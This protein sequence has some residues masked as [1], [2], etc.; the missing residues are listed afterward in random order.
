M[1]E[2]ELEPIF[3][4]GL[5]ELELWDE[6]MQAWINSKGEKRFEE[7]FKEKLIRDVKEALETSG[8]QITISN[9]LEAVKAM[10]NADKGLFD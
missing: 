4:V 10:S 8:L 7:G 6:D 9:G 3:E 5:G 1:G 2:L